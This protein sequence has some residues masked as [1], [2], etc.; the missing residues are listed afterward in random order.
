MNISCLPPGPLW[1]VSGMPAREGLFGT[2]MGQATE[3]F[4]KVDTIVLFI[5]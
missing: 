4:H 5:C 3:C 2:V 1:D